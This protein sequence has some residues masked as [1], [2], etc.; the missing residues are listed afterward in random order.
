MDNPSPEQVL[1]ACIVFD[2]RPLGGPTGLAAALRDVLAA[3]PRARH[4]LRL[5]AHDVAERRVPVTMFGNVAVQRRGARRGRVDVKAAGSMQLASAG[6]VHALEL[7]LDTTN[8]VDRFREAGRREIYQ[9]QQVREIT[10]AYQHLIRLRLVHQLA[11]L[12]RGEAPDNFVDP[13]TL[14]HA[15]E[16][17]FRDALKTVKG[18][19]ASFR[20]RFA[21]DLV[22]S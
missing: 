10:D 17:L 3:A 4:F 1:G 9:D 18:V 15:D 16:L 5:M 2:L 22:P 20:D 7:G 14:S 19:Q 11:Q 6:R 12:A 21:T 13:R 8:T